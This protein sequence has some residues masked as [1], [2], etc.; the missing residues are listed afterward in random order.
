[1][2][3]VRFVGDV[4][5]SWVRWHRQISDADYV[6]ILAMNVG[7]SMEV[8]LSGISTPTTLERIS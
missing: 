4:G 1:M 8:C 3:R 6:R 7:D 2:Y 5:V